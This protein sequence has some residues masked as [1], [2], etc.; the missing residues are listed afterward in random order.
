MI[1]FLPIAIPM[2]TFFIYNN[3]TYRYLGISGYTT[4][5]F[6]FIIEIHLIDGLNVLD[7]GYFLT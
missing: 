1:I 3:L 7:V 6:W 5:M 2:N 4:L